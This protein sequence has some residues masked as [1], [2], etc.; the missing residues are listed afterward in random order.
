M[1]QKFIRV[2]YEFRLMN[3]CTRTAEITGWESLPFYV[4][5]NISYSLRFLQHETKCELS[6]YP[7]YSDKLWHHNL[8]YC[9]QDLS[10]FSTSL[11]GS[12]IHQTP[13]LFHKFYRKVF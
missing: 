1:L 11:T 8:Q 6:L 2:S 13:S 9:I 3:F 4:L 12:D 7:L 10:E 5:F